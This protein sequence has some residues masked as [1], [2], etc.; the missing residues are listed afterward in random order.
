MPAFVDTGLNVVHVD[1]VAAGHVLAHAR[2]RIGERY[3]LGGQD[4]TLRD[5]LVQIAQL[6][7]RSPP[8]IRLPR[9]PLI[10]LAFVAELVARL[11]GG[12]TRMTVEGL[13]MAGKRMFFSSQKAQ[14][15]LGYA[16]R[17]PLVAFQDALAWA[18][19]QGLLRARG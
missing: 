11:T 15:E 5:I 8:R 1:D 3:I 16:W 12:S 17:A 10:P 18:D 13:R 6:T 4:M 2:G 19:A 7:G 9:A 14:R